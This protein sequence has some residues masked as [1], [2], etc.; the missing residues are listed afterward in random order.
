ML[1]KRLITVLTFSDGVLFRTKLFKPDYRYTLNFVDAWSVDEII[2]LDVSRTAPDFKDRSA[3]LKVVERF[4]RRCFVPLTIGGGIRAADD[5]RYALEAGADKIAV[6]TG[7]LQR[8]DIINEI[9]GLYG[10]QC[11]VVSIDAKKEVD[12]SYHAYHSFGKAPS[13]RRVVDWAREAVNLGAGELLVNSIERDGSLQGYDLELCRQVS[14]AVEVPVLICSGAGSWAHFQAGFEE[15][16]ADAVCT[17]NIYH[18]TESSIKNAK[19]Y[20]SAAGIVVRV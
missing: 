2:V 20:L 8:P 5:V 7:A 15:G 1:R 4:A 11:V 16:G 10:S 18:F 9:S 13:G 17:S 14:S 19:E 3:F 6:N 12:G